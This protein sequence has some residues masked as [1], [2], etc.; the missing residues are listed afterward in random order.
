[1]PPPM[2]QSDPRPT[3]A[4]GAPSPAAAAPPRRKTVLSLIRSTGQSH[5]GN[6]LGAIRYWVELSERADRRCFFGVADLHAL[7]TLPD[8]EA[9]R[10]YTPEL[11]LDALAA[12][13]DPSKSIVFAQSSVP[14]TSELFWLLCCLMPLGL[15]QRATTFKD[16]SEKQPEN[17]NAGLLNYPVLMAADILGPRAELVPVGEDQEQHLEMARE[18]A[19]KFNRAF[20]TP[21]EPL[22]PEPKNVTVEPVRVPGLDGTGKMGKSEGN[23]LMLSD[24]PEQ[25]WEKLRPAVTDPARQRRTDPGTP[26][27]CNVYG[28]HRLVSPRETVDE[29][30]HGCR[31]A[32]IGCIDCKKRL[33]GHVV[34]LLAPFRERRAALARRPDAARE[35]LADGAAR[36]RAVI[37]ETVAIAKDRMGLVRLD[38]A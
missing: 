31:T 34:A 4:P 15:L 24:T 23:A 9:I 21:D 20:C 30:A 36:A 33:H 35:V 3:S 38:R 26:E 19:G 25:M 17:V 10:R 16:K 12:G 11:V 6:Y 22:F 5:L 8:P 18:L 32:G 27:I 1:M 37:G 29:V 28:I 13:V 7:T 2:A 14:E